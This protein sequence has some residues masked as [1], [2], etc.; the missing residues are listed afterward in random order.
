MNVRIAQETK[1][2]AAVFSM[3]NKARPPRS[4]F[5]TNPKE[6]DEDSDNMF[7][8]KYCMASFVSDQQEKIVSSYIVPLETDDVV[9]REP[10]LMLSRLFRLYMTI[11]PSSRIADQAGVVLG[12]RTLH[13]ESW[14]TVQPTDV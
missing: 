8:R 14:H 7:V 1:V 13:A 9:V 2:A 6:C 5:A 10:C 3:I 12:Y 4:S 11:F